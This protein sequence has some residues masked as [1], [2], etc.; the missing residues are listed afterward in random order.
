MGVPMWVSVLVPAPGCARA[1]T[2]GVHGR[3][4]GAGVPCDMRSTETVRGSSV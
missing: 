4:P 2:L 1:G 3:A